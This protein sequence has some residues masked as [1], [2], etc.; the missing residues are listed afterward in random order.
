MLCRGD[1]RGTRAGE[2][3]FDLADVFLDECQGVEQR[4]A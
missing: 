3:H 2:H 1:G 4:R